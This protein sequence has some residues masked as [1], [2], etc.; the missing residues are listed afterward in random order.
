MISKKEF[1]ALFRGRF[2][3]KISESVVPFDEKPKNKTAFLDEL[4]E[5]L[6]ER[7]YYPDLP[8]D[9]IVTDRHNRVPRIVPTFSYSDYC[10]YYFCIKTLE[11]CIAV[12]RVSGTFGGW[13]L[14]NAMRKKEERE[15]ASIAAELSYGSMNSYNPYKWTQNWR[16]FQKL[17]YT[18]SQLRNHDCVVRFDIANFYD[19]INLGLLE[20]KI[21]LAASIEEHYVI[22]LLFHFL[23]HWNRCFERYGAKT[24][25]IPQDEIGDCSRILANFYLQEYD[26]VLKAACERRDAEYLRYADD[27]IIFVVSR[28]SGRE[29]L[30][31]ATQQL[32]R[33]NLSINSGKVMEFSDHEQFENYWA[34]DIFELL[35]DPTDL[36]AINQGVQLY[37][38]RKDRNVV[39]RRDSVL[40]RL[41]AS[42]LRRIDP[43][44]RHRLMSELLDPEFI[45]MQS[46]WVFRRLEGL[47]DSPDELFQVL[48]AQVP[49]ALFN[50]FHYNLIRYYGRS[51]PGYALDGIN[52]RIRE[53]KIDRM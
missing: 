40:R 48:D 15:I 28:Q 13:T 43:H 6:V 19:S 53:L 52:Q 44:L 39:F 2:W 34:F 41:L 7:R 4:Y 50:S 37:F 36:A 47:M 46:A 51:R 25:G 45:S 12:N 14:G 42:D 3:S 22:E 24:V 26:T 29:L 1:Q 31:E 33:I 11:H 35:G 17:A 30:F 20:N 23:R 32:F 8:R 16:E 9:Y 27:Q 10:V 18:Y 21:R 38:E 49:I 5:R